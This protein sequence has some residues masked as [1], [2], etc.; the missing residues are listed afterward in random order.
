MRIRTRV[1]D[2]ALRGPSGY[3]TDR[4]LAKAMGI[5]ETTV[6][7][8][9]KGVHPPSNAFI[10]GALKAYPGKNFDDLFYADG[11]PTTERELVE[12]SR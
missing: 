6:H 4:A 2:V 11:A 3:F 8:V 1:F 10:A 7:R 9:K 5:H 12:V